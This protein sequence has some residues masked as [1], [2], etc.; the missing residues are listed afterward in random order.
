MDEVLQSAEPD[1]PCPR[2][3]VA[4]GMITSAQG[5]LEVPHVEAPAGAKELA[6]GARAVRITDR[7]DRV[8][9]LIPGIR[10]GGRQVA[11][12][13]ISSADLMR[14]E[15][16][17]CIGLLERGELKG[18]MSL[19]NLGSHWKWISVNRDGRIAGSWTTLTGEMIHAV[20]S[21]TLLAAS[22]RAGR[23]DSFDVEWVRRGLHEARA[24]GLAR[25]LF[26]VR[27]LHQQGYGTPEERLSYLYG[28]FLANEIESAKNYCR[29]Y[30]EKV[31][32][33]GSLAL[34]TLWCEC[35]QSVSISATVIEDR[36]KEAAYLNGLQILAKNSR[37]L[38]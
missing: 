9:I 14:G 37:L 5:L 15:E 2:Y 23:P 22:V 34:A 38:I 16:T 17:L 32:I 7:S 28:A 3:A 1:I 11:P 6:A 30:G 4:A 18:Q 31:L 8:L 20:Q 12:E 36:E 21:N 19:L 26:C 10:T 25:A 35:L 27:L 24:E 13:D 33:T 29:Q